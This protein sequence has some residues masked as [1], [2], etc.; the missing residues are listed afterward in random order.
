[1]KLARLAVHPAEPWFPLALSRGTTSDNCASDLVLTIRA[2][3]AQRLDVAGGNI[4]WTTIPVERSLLSTQASVVSRPL[5]SVG[6]SVACEP[7]R[8]LFLKC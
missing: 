7:G 8:P 6:T 2:P 1:M 3:T 4:A 5:P